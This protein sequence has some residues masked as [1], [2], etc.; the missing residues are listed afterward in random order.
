MQEYMI[1]HR[2]RLRMRAEELGVDNLRN[3]EVLELILC[4]AVPR[5]DM[6]VIA[7][8][9]IDRFGSV[10]NV[11]SAST[12]ELMSVDGVGNSIAEWISV[13]SELI[14]AYTSVEPTEQTRIIRHMD[15]I[16]YVLSACRE[17]TSPMCMVI[18]TDFNKRILMKSVLCD[19]L[20]WYHGEYMRNI[21]TEAISLQAKYAILVLNTGPYPMDF[22]ERDMEYLLKLSRSLRA[23]DV[24]LIDCILFSLSDVKSLNACGVMDAIRNESK[25]RS[26][27]EDYAGYSDR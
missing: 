12:E 7:R 9:L 16:K 18:Y 10:K 17:H 13:T 21:I 3:Y 26:V 19:S 6:N 20:S 1:G 23:V 11:F 8:R 24:E 2:E 15:A 27:H 25:K 5:M 4:Y 14:S 22:E